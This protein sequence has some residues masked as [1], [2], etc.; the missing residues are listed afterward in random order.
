[1][2]GAG[3]RSHLDGVWLFG[4]FVVSHTEAQRVFGTFNQHE[5]RTLIKE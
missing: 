4:L 2:G 1:M 5:C 3:A